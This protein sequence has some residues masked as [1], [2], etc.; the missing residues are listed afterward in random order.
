MVGT[1][2]SPA[3]VISS[4]SAWQ[5][6]WEINW[7]VLGWERPMKVLRLFSFGLKFVRRL[8]C[9]P[10]PNDFRVLLL[11]ALPSGTWF[12]WSLCWDLRCAS[13]LHRA[14]D[15][16]ME[17]QDRSPPPVKLIITKRWILWYFQCSFALWLAQ[18][19]NFLFS[20]KWN[21]IHLKHFKGKIERKIESIGS[22]LRLIFLISS[23]GWEFQWCK[24]K[25]KG[26]NLTKWK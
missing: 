14:G 16:K 11:W 7:E 3:I 24:R 9:L 22:A 10:L 2:I 26:T 13:P 4:W 12:K 1:W 25:R 23:L 8:Y 20:E 6:L 19:I 18:D 21:I 15:T 5:E 17:N